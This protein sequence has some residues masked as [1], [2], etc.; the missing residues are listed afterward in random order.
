V[1][2]VVDTRAA[3]ETLAVLEE[4]HRAILVAIAMHKVF[5]RGR[6]SK[7]VEEAIDRILMRMSWL[8]EQAEGR[9]APSRLPGG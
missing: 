2:L 5:A 8:R 3:V 1:A 6:T 7:A 9:G 4:A